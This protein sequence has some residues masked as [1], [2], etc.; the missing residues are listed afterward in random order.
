LPVTSTEPRAEK[1]EFSAGGVVVRGGDV[2]VIVPVKRGQ[3]GE[4]VL[5]LPKGHPDPGESPWQAATREVREE[6]GLQAE[7]VCS[8]GDT[9]YH[10]QRKGKPVAKVVAFYLFRYV[11]GDL[12]DHDHEIEEARWMPLAEAGEAL[13]YEGER[14]IVRGALSR[15][16]A[17][18]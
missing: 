10:Y 17:E 12:A 7:L 2:A 14:A 8:L 5:G 16:R 18:R 3:N 1:H 4:R 15:I 11:S 13:T 9:R 6:T